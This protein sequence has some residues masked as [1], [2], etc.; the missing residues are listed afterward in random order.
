MGSER[1]DLSGV[2]S[3]EGVAAALTVLRE[4]SGLSVRQ[5]ATDIGQPASTVGGWFSGR[6]LPPTTR[7][8][9][10]RDL[11]NGLGV[12]SAEHDTWISVLLQVQRQRR[13][14]IGD[15]PFRGL[16]TYRVEDADV[17]FGRDDVVTELV[18]LVTA[19]IDA[20]TD[21]RSVAVVG[22]SGVGKS[23]VVRAGLIPELTGDGGHGRDSWR[24]EVMTPGT[25]PLAALARSTAALEGPRCELL[26]VDQF[27]ELWTQGI[28]A[29]DRSTFVTRLRDWVRVPQTRRAVVLTVRADYYGHLSEQPLLLPALRRQQVLVGPMTTEA[30]RDVITGPARVRGVSIEDG[31][32]DVLLDA[33]RAHRA[34]GR[35]GG[36][37][38]HLS[39][40]LAA[41]WEHGDGRRLTLADYHA[42]GGVEGAIAQTAE[43]AYESM[44]EESRETARHLL[45]R[46]VTMDDDG[47][48]SRRRVTGEE[49]RALREAS[50]APQL[51]ESVLDRLVEERLVILD[52]HSAEL[53][54]EALIWA[55][56]RL[57]AWVNDNRAGLPVR[58]MLTRGTAEWVAGARDEG[59]LLRGSRLEV[60]RQWVSQNP[61]ELTEDE[62]GFVAASTAQQV[63]EVE[64]E[65]R[66]HARTR[67]FLLAVSSLSV[68]ALVLAGVA[69]FEWRTADEGRSEALSRQLATTSGML[70]DGRLP[71]SGQVAVA[72]H[73]TADTLEARSA[74][75]DAT[76][77]PAVVRRVSPGGVRSLAA[78]PDGSLIAVG[79]ETG[80]LD[81]VRYDGTDMTTLATVPLPEETGGEPASTVQ[82]VEFSPGADVV[83]AVGNET[84]QLV[85][86]RDPTHPVASHTQV[87]G[88]ST[89]L[90]VAWSPDGRFLYIATAEAGLAR[91]EVSG[92]DVVRRLPPLTELHGVLRTVQVSPDGS[93]LV[94]ANEAGDIRTWRLV[95][96]TATPAAQID[97]DGTSSL[98]TSVF[99]PDGAL[100]AIG[101]KDRRIRLFAD[102]GGGELTQRRVLGGFGSWVSEAAFSRDGELVAVG[103]SD[104]TLRVWTPGGSQVRTL[105]LSAA[106]AT[107]AP[108]GDRGW[109][110]STTDGM[111]YAVPRHGM[112]LPAMQDSIFAI[113]YDESGDRLVS[114]PGTG[115]GALHLWDTSDPLAPVQVT[116][117]RAPDDAG[118]LDGCADISDDGSL[119]ASGTASGSVLVWD[120]T[121]PASPELLVDTKVSDQLI[122]QVAFTA[123]DARVAVVG[124]DGHARLVDV[125]S[126][127]VTTDHDTGQPVMNVATGP[128]GEL[129][130]TDISGDGRLWTDGTADGG[131]DGRMDAGS[132]A[133]GVDLSSTGTFAAVG[134]A[135]TDLHLWDVSDP[136]HP[137]QVGRPL[138][139]PGNTLFSVA[140]SPD[141][142][143][144]AAAV[145]DGTV[146]VWRRSEDGTFHRY[147]VLRAASAPM[148]SLTWSPDGRVLVAGGEEGESRMWLVDPADAERRVCRV[149][150]DALTEQEW[151][152]VAPGAP[153]EAPCG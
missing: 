75:L 97:G 23:S 79:R 121:D 120:I 58:E 103:S 93:L 19:I 66:E 80:G 150:G 138:T 128:A 15:S 53:S 46:M 78:S 117:I 145:K 147:A 132:T 35:P 96:D 86:V 67:R 30:L 109:A 68:V 72:A 149:V 144:V 60:V 47:A 112:V 82:K 24:V 43:A 102:T 114:A 71:V 26:V 29:G 2:D 131:A 123:D 49:L 1:P 111:T 76:S 74:L 52:Q 31:L 25:A 17:F 108:L 151:A 45:L 41:M 21:V 104:N 99:S 20:R 22:P 70:R 3:P 62:R 38:P 94:A 18:D 63:F 106:I 130:T 56:P 95:R 14:A 90:D 91:L 133:Y 105:T 124:D 40:T 9:V 116:T 4:R 59:L 81:L 87:P 119:V 44:D 110:A 11:L 34:I 16:E 129:A 13:V 37:L 137:R 6:H 64:R 98:F 113:H 57:R 146:W 77:A 88:A 55:W 84:V 141:D 61:L 143:M 50:A 32:V 28:P 142:S 10:V 89:M 118:T 148:L 12:P 153:F 83:A 107:V 7:L 33:G 42:V 65:Q 136:T 134:G 73:E 101:G 125:A 135:D 8:D 115:D 139:G 126:G 54:H 39:H 140:F 100:L 152:A 51:V 27:E 48:A 92:T 122:E 85:D 36:S 5:V 69:A 127:D